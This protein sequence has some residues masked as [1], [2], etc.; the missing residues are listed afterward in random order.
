ME[1]LAP[2][3]RGISSC[4]VARNGWRN[5]NRDSKAFSLLAF[6]STR[7][8]A[9]GDT[10]ASASLT[11]R[12]GCARYFVR[13]TATTKHGSRDSVDARQCA[14]SKHFFQPALATP[15]PAT[16]FPGP[17]RKLPAPAVQDVWSHLQRPLYRRSITPCSGRRTRGH[18]ITSAAERERIAEL[19]LLAGRRAKVSTAYASALKYLHAGRRLLTD[20]TW[21]HNY[22]LIFSVDYLLAACELLTTDMVAA[23]NR[24]SILAERAKSAHDIALVTRLHVTLYTDC[25]S[26]RSC[27]GGLS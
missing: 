22:G 24:L 15:L 4:L 11:T 19:N 23:E 20:E 3:L 14:T 7:S 13:D 26:Q 27:R 10:G 25:G 2:R 18:L 9:T 8:I 1:G 21:K 6:S 17:C 12:S 16:A 5:G